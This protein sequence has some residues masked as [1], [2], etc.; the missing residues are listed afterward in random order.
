MIKKNKK[1]I[2][3]SKN[4]KESIFAVFFKFFYSRNGAKK[5]QKPFSTKVNLKFSGLF[6]YNK[7]ARPLYSLEIVLKLK[8]FEAVFHDTGT[9]FLKFFKFHTNQG[10]KD[11][12]L[13][14]QSNHS[15]DY[16][17]KLFLVEI[18]NKPVRSHFIC[19][20]LDPKSKISNNFF[21]NERFFRKFFKRCSNH[22]GKRFNL[23]YYW[24]HSDYYLWYLILRGKR[25]IKT[26]PNQSSSPFS[27]VGTITFQT[28][29]SNWATKWKNMVKFPMGPNW[30]NLIFSR[31][32]TL[33]FIFLH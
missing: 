27:M 17:C 25:K 7:P 30:C 10:W 4:L 18:Q 15:D 6:Y 21:Y 8:K 9:F 11:F 33:L 28:C 14:H 19:S 12:R 29:F 2:K 24:I 3:N 23:I 31:K 22:Q 32:T 5:I 16:L 13:M 26:H 20:K 1:K